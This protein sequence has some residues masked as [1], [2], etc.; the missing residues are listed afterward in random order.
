[1]GDAYTIRLGS[2][3]DS[4]EAE[5]ES[6]MLTTARTLVRDAAIGY[7]TARIH[8]RSLIVAKNGRYDG[9]AT[10]KAKAHA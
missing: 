1:M 4:A 9:A 10:E 7:G 2:T 8:R 6:A 5:G 3:G